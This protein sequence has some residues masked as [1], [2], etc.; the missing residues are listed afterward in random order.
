MELIGKSIVIDGAVQGVGYRYAA[1]KMAKSLGVKGYVKNQ[2]DGTVLIIAEGTQL[3]INTF[4][5]WC[6]NG[7]SSAR[8]NN[9]SVNQ[10]SIE[11]FSTFTIM[12]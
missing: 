12:Y 1:N 2:F 5:K 11:G 6:Y 3:Q 10:K 4:I 8:V 7:P 9:V